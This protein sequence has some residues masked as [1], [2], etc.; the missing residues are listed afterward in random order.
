MKVIKKK[1]DNQEEPVALL[2]Y[3]PEGV[4][5][6]TF[7]ADAPSP[8]FIGER[9]GLRSLSRQKRRELTPEIE[10]ETFTDVISLLAKLRDG[11]HEYK[12]VIVDT[13]DWLEQRFIQPKVAKD[14]G[15]QSI[16]DIGFGKG[17]K[18]AAEEWQKLLDIFD[19][20]LDRGMN[21]VILCHAAITKHRNPE[22]EDFQRW[23]PSLHSNSLALLKG[24]ADAV[25]F[26]RFEEAVAS[27]EAGGTYGVGG[28]NH[29]LCTE[30]RAAFDAKN[31]YGLP[32][33]MPLAWHEFERAVSRG[34]PA[35]SDDIL[36][37]IDSLLSNA[38]AELKSETEKFKQHAGDDAAK[39]A[40]LEDWL[41]G[42]LAA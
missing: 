12:S 22:G 31:R 33:R 9:R 4:G 14:K 2:V 32:F 41:R 40:K 29:V 28:A 21:V 27:K 26:A 5:K 7:A 30:H 20:L 11:E 36:D 1:P 24:W 3:G 17:F 15:K 10:P 19:E 39:L 6:T 8:F 35:S 37:R 18:I 23:Q 38:S 25:L 34:A 16:E 42:K 13:A